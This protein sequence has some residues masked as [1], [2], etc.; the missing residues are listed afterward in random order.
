MY[1][2]R[3][4]Q[5]VVWGLRFLG[6]ASCALVGLILLFLVADSIPA[7]RTLGDRLIHDDSWHP[8]EHATDGTFGMLPIVIGSLTVTLGSIL[9]AAPLG[10]A[11]A[12]FCHFYAPPMLAGFYRRMVE[13]L[14]GIPS[15]VFGFWGLAVLAPMIST[16][17]RPPGHSMLAGILVVALMILPTIALISET[18]LAAVPRSHI[19]GA[20]ALGMGRWSIIRSIVL[21]SARAGIFTAMI[22]GIARAVGET[23]AVVMVCGNIVRVP[24]SVFDSVRTLTA[25]IALE[26]GYSVGM[27]RSALFVSGLLLL[28]TAI[29][30][31]TIIGIVEHRSKDREGGAH[32]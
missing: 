32:V 12:I 16:L 19:A 14:A 15:V 18:A 8:S 6:V 10:L 17:L 2:S 25:N 21:P 29:A 24:G 30:L 23:M 27:H 5:W 22:L 20:A 31:T 7:L 9:I 26:M 3:I 28:F 4:D 1:P 13:L 11:S